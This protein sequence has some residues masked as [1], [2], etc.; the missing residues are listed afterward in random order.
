[1][2]PIFPEY[3]TRIN[4]QIRH[5]ISPQTSLREQ[6]IQNVYDLVSSQTNLHRKNN[7]YHIESTSVIISRAGFFVSLQKCVVITEEW[8]VMINSEE[9]IGTTEYLTL[10]TRLR[11]RVN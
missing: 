5:R 11:I 3:D 6:R 10:Q 9:L 4:V 1:L 7:S 2:K 8:N